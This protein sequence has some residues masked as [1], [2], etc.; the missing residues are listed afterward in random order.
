D[1]LSGTQPN[2]AHH[3][4]AGL[5]AAGS[6]VWTVNFDTLIERASGDGLRTVAWPADPLPDTQLLK[7]HGSVGGNLV[8]T[9]RQVIGKL[10]G[11][12]EER[13]RADVRG[14]TVLFIGYRGRDLDFQPLWDEVLSE[15]ATVVWFDRWAGDAMSEATFKRKLLAGVNARG[16]LKLAPPAPLPPGARPDAAHNPSWDFI[17]WCQDRG[18]IHVDPDLVLRLF[19]DRPAGERSYPPLPGDSTSAR[20]AVQGMLGDYKGARASYWH[21]ARVPGYQWRAAYGPTSFT[22]ATQW[23]RC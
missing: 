11:K 8:V 3:A 12:W 19:E 4:L 7:P 13:L 1:V 15:A 18:L 16:K 21:A 6:R 17:A 22:A 2:A 23:P 10:G 9:A 5:A 14:R 20:P